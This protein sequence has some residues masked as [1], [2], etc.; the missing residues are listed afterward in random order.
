[1]RCGNAG[2]KCAISFSYDNF[3]APIEPP[4]AESDSGRGGVVGESVRIISGSYAGQYGF[5]RRL[6]A[7]NRY[8]IK[9]GAGRCVSKSRRQFKRDSTKEVRHCKPLA[10]LL[11]GWGGGGLK[12]GAYIGRFKGPA[13]YPVAALIGGDV[14]AQSPTS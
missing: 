5:V 4:D 2:S 6:K 10:A 12:A 13:R 8:L 3:A 9:I 1:M 7:N 11:G 14:V